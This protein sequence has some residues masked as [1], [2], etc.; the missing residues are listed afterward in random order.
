MSFLPL[1]YEQSEKNSHWKD[2]YSGSIE[3]ILQ[4]I[5]KS[6]HFTYYLTARHFHPH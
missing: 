5:P 4:S 3:K 6:R 2:F 1:E